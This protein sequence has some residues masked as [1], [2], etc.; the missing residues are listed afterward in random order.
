MEPGTRQVTIID[1]LWDNEE[2]KNRRLYDEQERGLQRENIELNDRIKRFEKQLEKDHDKELIKR[3][4]SKQAIEFTKLLTK[5]D[6]EIEQLNEQV[7]QLSK[8]S[9]L[10]S[11]L[12][13][14]NIEKLHLEKRL[15]SSVS[16]L[17]S[18]TT[19]NV[20]VKLSMANPSSLRFT[21]FIRDVRTSKRNLQQTLSQPIS[22]APT[23]TNEEQSC[24]PGS[25]GSSVFF[26]DPV[27]YQALQKMNEGFKTEIQRLTCSNED[28]TV[29]LKLQFQQYD[30]LQQAYKQLE[31]KYNQ[32]SD[33]EKVYRKEKLLCDSYCYENEQLKEKLLYIENEINHKYSNEYNKQK[34]K[35]DLLEDDL[36]TL[37]S[38][39]NYQQDL[40]MKIEHLQKDLQLSI[41]ECETTSALNT[42]LRNEITNATHTNER[43][44]EECETLRRALIAKSDEYDLKQRENEQLKTKNIDLESIIKSLQDA[45]DLQK[46]LNDENETNKQELKK[47]QDDFE[48]F[49]KMHDTTKQEHQTTIHVL[50]DKIQDLERKTELQ[51]SKYEEI[52]LQLQSLKTQ[53]HRVL[54][55]STENSPLTNNNYHNPLTIMSNSQ[56]LT[57]DDSA[58]IH[59]HQR[60]KNLNDKLARIVVA[61]YSYEPLRFSPNDHPEIELPLKLGEYYLIYGN[62]DEDGFYDGRNLEGRYGLIPSNFIELV[63]NPND[64]PENTK[65]IIQK[66]IGNSYHH[67]LTSSLDSDSSNM[68]SSIHNPIVRTPTNSNA[69][70]TTINDLSYGKNI[71]HPTNLHIE[72]LFSNSVLIAWDP[73]L[74]TIQILGYQVMLDQTLYTTIQSNERTHVLIENI[75]LNEKHHRIS[76][77]TITQLGL[78]RDQQCTL[79]L[80]NSKDLSYIPKDLRVDRINQTSAVISWWPASNDI[81]HKLFVNDKE[82]QTIKP[83]TYRFKLTNL[84]PNTIHKIKIKAKPSITTNIQQQQQLASSIE[85][86]TTSFDESIEPP[87]RVQAIADLQ[88][89]TVRVSWE[90]ISTARGYRILIDGRQILDI[91]NPL[92]DQTVINSNILHHGRFLTIRTLNDNGGESRDSIPIDIDDILKKTSYSSSTISSEPSIPI[93]SST[94]LK[95]TTNGKEISKSLTR[96]L[97]SPSTISSINTDISQIELNSTIPKTI[98]HN[99]SAFKQYDNSDS[100]RIRTTINENFNINKSTLSGEQRSI[101]LTTNKT[102]RLQ[103]SSAINNHLLDKT[104]T[105]PRLFVALFDYD[106]QAMSPNQNSDEELPFKQGQIIKIYGNQDA[107]GFY[108][109]QTENGQTGYVPSNMVSE[110]EVSDSE[111]QSTITTV[112]TK[113]RTSSLST[114]KSPK[115]IKKMIAL[116]DYNPNEHSPNANSKDELSFHSGDIIYVHGNIHD[117]GFY[118]GE[119]ENGKKGLVPSNY[120]KEISNENTIE[121]STESNEKQ[122][123]ST[124][125]NNNNNETTT[126]VNNNN[127]AT[128]N[129]NNTNETTTNVNNNNEATTNVNNNSDATTNIN[130]NNETTTTTT[131]TEQ[132]AEQPPAPSTEPPKAGFFDRFKNT[133]SWNL[134]EPI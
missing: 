115:S 3:V 23:S 17:N 101:P 96:S 20:D 129:I 2:S 26:D 84:V 79:L 123:T 21:G 132:T 37:K 130:N 12:R 127:E 34:Q 85:F 71:P 64:L 62:I 93:I 49:Q 117:D 56:I 25:S 57:R 1:E 52:L 125:V 94:L 110:V 118:S 86:R 10:E 65:H 67:E 50:Q 113:H 36:L 27:N 32:L 120:L 44:T 60:L 99:K 128:T 24:S 78:S 30:E 48:Q 83:G 116:F 51:T 73:P 112:S 69:S 89:N 66:L 16:S 55:S 106:P 108:I 7:K 80:T 95:S 47:K 70:D 103:R 97:E 13:Q 4:L 18:T 102:L 87:R 109:G 88:S 98:S 22:T 75:N 114:P 9:L 53:Q 6:Q 58:P 126:N 38:T 45:N 77:Q 31:I 28:N 90:P 15:L 5:K 11:A 82:I 76:I 122:E 35:I 14:S 105:P 41:K 40:Q 92:N 42:Q 61:K 29:K 59:S 100:N 133:F 131:T 91:T 134:N 111:N 54:P 104:N 63:K 119:L 68:N 81:I 19:T 74:S 72:K 43:L 33:I 124:N 39:Q 8:S 121:K 107:D 46:R